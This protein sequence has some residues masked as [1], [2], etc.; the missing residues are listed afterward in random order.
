MKEV[1]RERHKFEATG[2]PWIDA[3][4]LGFWEY[5]QTEGLYSKFGVAL[6]KN[7][8][9]SAQTSKQVEDFLR[10]TFEKVKSA[11]YIKETGNK[12]CIFNKS[13]GDFE[14]VEKIN[15]VD[16]VS[17]LIAGSGTGDAKPKY[18][19]CPF[20]KDKRKKWK[21]LQE[22][23]KGQKVEFKINKK[24]EIPYSSSWFRWPSF[25]P[26]LNPNQAINCAF[27]GREIAAVDIHSNNYPF[28]VP[29]RNWS[30]FYSQLS[31]ELKMCSFCEIASLFGVNRI[32]YNLNRVRKTLF[33]AIP[34]AS[35]LE[36]IGEFWTDVRGV[37][38]YR[39]LDNPSNIFQ[40][41]YRY[42]YL[43]ESILAFAYELYQALRKAR[44]SDKRLRITSTK[45]WHFFLGNT[46]GQ[47]VSFQNY[48]LFDEMHRLFE[49]FSE[50]EKEEI[51][52]S[53]IFSALSI[54]E[55]KNYNNL[56]R[57]SLSER[58]IKNA[59]INDIS[60]RII[61]KKGEKI[62]GFAEFIKLYNISRR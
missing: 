31:G 22:R 14:I 33:I 5:I 1:Q 19:K 48:A 38:G 32:F 35:S 58:V 55:G 40:D 4:I 12:I 59:P 54:K 27:C 56:Y 30:N 39:S 16:V 51:K 34:H 47:T 42:T 44:A 29:V 45:T 17:K 24:G 13:K 21:V 52:F 36:E 6:Q 28:L 26:N 11:R 60:E 15:L 43:N 50:I 62:G 10:E 53:S 61:W 49:L 37:V 3:G 25:R 23:Y 8:T 2:D 7:Y 46:S 41:G 57:E 18:P 9:I 20:P